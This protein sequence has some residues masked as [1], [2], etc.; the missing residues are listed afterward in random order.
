[1]PCGS[2]IFFRESFLAVH[3]PTFSSR[4]LFETKAVNSSVERWIDVQSFFI[5]H[6]WILGWEKARMRTTVIALKKLQMCYEK[7]CEPTL[8]VKRAEREAGG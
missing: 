4:G 6:G 1:M 2:S 8:R 5:Y 7:S 3:K